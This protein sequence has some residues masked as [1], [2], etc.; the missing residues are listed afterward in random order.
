MFLDYS[1]VITDP[2]EHLQDQLIKQAFMDFGKGFMGTA[3]YRVRGTVIVSPDKKHS[4]TKEAC[5]NKSRLQFQFNT[6]GY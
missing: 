3:G 2:P 4:L 1:L 5:E 6:T